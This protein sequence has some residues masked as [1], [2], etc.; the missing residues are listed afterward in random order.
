MATFPLRAA[1]SRV[2]S[3]GALLRAAAALAALIEIFEEAQAMARAA[4]KRYPFAEW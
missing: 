3:F 2:P 4:Y 1:S